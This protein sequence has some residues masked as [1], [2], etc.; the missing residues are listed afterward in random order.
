MS[1][2][3]VDE[4]TPLLYAH[5][6][7]RTPIPW[8]QYSIILFI[9][10]AEPL[11]SQ[12]IYPF[13]PQLIRDVGVTHGN[14]AQVGYYLGLMQ[15]IFYTTQATTILPW[16]RIS[17]HVGRKPIILIGLF[18]LSLSMFCFGLSKTFWGLVISRSLNG[19]LNGNVGVIKGMMTEMTDSTNIA[20]MYAY[21]PIA[22]SA[23]GAIGPLIGG[24]LSRPADRFPNVFGNSRFLRNYPYFLPCAIP[25]AFSAVSW[26]VAYLFLRETVQS[27]VPASRL[28]LIRKSKSNPARDDVA[29]CGALLAISSPPV[30]VSDR[31]KPLR[32]LFIPR[33]LITASNYA[34]LALVDIAFRALQPL[35][36]STPIELGGL[37]L[38]P[39]SIGTVLSVYGIMNGF[40][41]VLFF[42]KIYNC[43]G[44]K[45][46]FVAGLSATLPAFAAFPVMSHLAKTQGLS[47]AVWTVVA[48]QTSCSLGLNMAYGAAFIF[49]SAASPNRASLGTMN[50]LCQMTV[51]IMRAIGPAASTSLF[52]LSIE[53]HYMGG[54]LVYYVMLLLLGVS[55][56]FAS[57]LPCKPWGQ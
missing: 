27:P 18:G 22:W 25:A 11:T 32:E 4:E 39:S 57:L 9:Q 38:P 49:I 6:T 2:A 26:L 28:L 21:M 43:W 19:A 12:V 8:S 56:L 16:S 3:P 36:F 50:G 55:L 47:L 14:E 5:P 46:T 35:F 45:K 54:Y 44:A 13:A 48:V 31:P 40:L 37:G 33:V 7:T 53:H 42:A 34:L 20:E 17:D 29:R 51:S 52:S 30:S 15:S 1:S 23:G 24:S 10:L 41:Q